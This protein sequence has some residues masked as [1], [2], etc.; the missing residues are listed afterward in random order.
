MGAPS[1]YHG[2]MS[3]EESV[4]PDDE[5]LQASL[6]RLLA[7]LAKLVVAYGMPFA[8]LDETLRRAVVAEAHAAHPSLPEHRRASRISAATGLNRREVKRLL[9]QQGSSPWQAPDPPRSPAAMVFAHWRATP[10][11]RDAQGEPLE[12]PRLGPAPSFESLAQEVTRDV[13]PR[14][15]LEELLRLKLAW[16]DAASD[17]VA[18]SAQAFVPRG[19]ANRMASWL[20][21]NVGDH[22]ACAVANVLGHEP[23]H[24]EQAIAAQGLS[25]ASVAR[26]RPLLQAHWQRLTD[27]LVPLLER[28]I[29]EDAAR[30]TPAVERVRFG[31][32]AHDSVNREAH[33]PPSS[34]P[35]NERP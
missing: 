8:V 34:D 28:L 33:A 18:L 20:G 14:A 4:P 24:F 3:P 35:P 30:G 17:R 11:Y 29:E 10:A 21:A 6:A 15:L 12:L 32:Y 27:E 5:A 31:L 1:A 26:V 25:A 13:H 23:A 9:A 22:L 7:P 19:D 2:R 16:H